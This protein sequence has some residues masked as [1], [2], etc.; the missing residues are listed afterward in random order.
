[1]RVYQ[2]SDLAS[3]I[4]DHFHSLARSLT[5]RVLVKL[6]FMI[7][8]LAHVFGCGYHYIALQRMHAGFG[9]TWLQANGI[10]EQSWDVRYIYSLYCAI[11]TTA[12]V[13]YG[14]IT[15]IS[16]QEKIVVMIFILISCA[17]YA[18]T[19]NT[20]GFLFQEKDIK[21]RRQK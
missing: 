16:I 19:I 10:A 18:Y 20:I 11:V 6:F 12:T 13:G 17:Q 8:F 21:R 7:F 9:D 3:S 5:L 15:P 4:I 1:M 14:D 2:I